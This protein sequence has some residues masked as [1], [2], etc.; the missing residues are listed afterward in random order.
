MADLP[1]T[2]GTRPAATHS[3]H[4]DYLERVSP[5]WL[6]NATPQ[7][8][9]QLKDGPVTLPDEYLQASA[10]QRQALQEKFTA[11]F[12]AQS[13]LD[14]AMASLQ[15][16]DSF[17]APLLTKALQAQF[18]VTLD[19]NTTLLQLNKTI[20]A[21]V[22]GIDIGSFEA[23]RLPLLQAALHNFEA[24][25][26]QPGAFHASS[27][28]LTQAVGAQ[29]VETL[30]TSL[31]VAQFTGLC[32]SLDIG[33]QYQRYLKDYLQ[34]T[35]TVAAQLLR[36]TFIGARKA[37]LAASAE[38]ALLQK[39]IEP[40]DYRMIVSV[41][42]GEK[43][44][45]MGK[46]QVWF[47]D[48]GLMKK[49][50]T[51][52]VVF[53]ICEKYRYTDEL[54]LYVP[55]D[56]HHP[57][58]RYTPEQ[59][60]ALFKQR[61]TAHDQPP[62][63]DGSPTTYQRFF[64]Q[65]VAYGDRPYYFSELTEDAP[66]ASTAGSL[67]HYVPLLN[68]LA[69]GIS[70]FGEV[71][72]IK[73]LPPV[74]RA[75]Q[76]PN[77]DPF[78]NP[79]GLLHKGRGLWA[80]NPDLWDYLYEQH[81]DKLIADAR[82]HAVPTAE[83][84]ARVRSEKLA[85][86]LNI[87]LLALNVASMFVPVLGEVMMGVMAAQLLQETFEGALEWTEGD[88]RAAKAHLL[89]VAENLAFLA[90]MA[91]VGKG[92]ATYAA[93][94]PVPLIEGLDPVTLPNGQERLSKA[95]VSAY[96]SP[97]TLPA[98]I[99]AN[100]QGQ[101]VYAGKTYIRQSGKVYEKTF[102][103]TLGCWRIKHPTDSEAY[104]PRLSHNGAGAWRHALERPLT[105]DRTTL[106]RRLGPVADG[107]SD[108]Q[109]LRIADISGTSD[110]AL[111]KM[112]LDNAL[113]PAPLTD[114]M[115]L[116]KA[117]AEV[118]QVIEQ[119]S[120]GE[121][122]DARYLYTL[123]LVTELPRWPVG[124]VLEV[125]EGAGLTG[126]SQR[127]GVERL[128]R[129]VKLKP[130]IRVSRADVLSSQL[131][132]Q[133]LAALDESEI[134]GLLGSEA[135][136]VI[137]H[138]PAE[139][140]KQLAEHARAREPALFESLYKGTDAR[141]PTV[142]KLQRLYPGLS[143]PAAQRALAE[144]GAEQLARL[145]DTGRVP[146]ALQENLQGHVQQGRLGHAYAGL[147][148]DNML[149]ADSKRLAL[150][151]LSKL[152]GWTDALRLEVR[153][154]DI[155][156]DLLD[157]IG[158]PAATQRKYLVKQGPRYQ[159]F[160]ERGEALNSVAR[161]GDNF[162]ASL[163]HAL[164]DDARQALGLPQV[165]QSL[166]LR[167]AIIDYATGHRPESAQIVEGRSRT[168][169][170]FNP[171]RRLSPKRFGYPASGRGQGVSPS[172][173]SRVQDVYPQLT[174]GQAN[175][176]ILQQMLADQSDSQIFNL[177]NNRL[178]E[179]RNLES[180][181]DSWVMSASP[182]AFVRSHSY[183]DSRPAMAQ[184]LKASWR[185]G[186]LPELPGATN[187]TLV[188]DTLLPSLE[189]DFS[190]VRTLNIRGRVLIDGQVEQL[191]GYFPNVQKLSLAGADTS[192]ASVPQ[193]LEGL[194]ALTNLSIETA[195]DLTE[196]VLARLEGL[197][198]LEELTLHSSW[199]SPRPL[200]VG[201]MSALRSLTVSG[202]GQYMFPDGVFE[203]PQLQRLDLKGA[204]IDS[205]P[206]QLFEPGR[207]Y[208]WSVLSLKWSR[209]SRERFRAAYEFVKAH[210][211][212]LMDQDEMVRD[213]CTG[214]LSQ[215][216]GRSAYSNTVVGGRLIAQ[217]FEYWP[218]TQA[219]LQAI[220]ALTTEYAQLSARFNVWRVADGNSLEA[221]SRSGIDSALRDCWYQGLLKRY[222]IDSPGVLSL[223]AMTV[224]DLPILPTEGFAHV[225]LLRVQNSR[226]PTEQMST[227]IR[228][229]SGLQSVDASN[230][231][232]TGLSVMPGEWAA[233]EHLD[234]SH[235]P[236]ETL[237]V[238]RL[239]QLRALSLRGT[240]LSTWP[241]GA[242]RLPQLDWLDLRDTRIT[243]V[244][245]AALASDRMLL[246]TN[247]VGTPLS[248]EAQAQ[249]AAAQQK[250]EHTR[251]LD[252]GTL[253]RF[254]QQP[255][256]DVFPPGESATAIARQLLPLLPPGST[257]RALSLPQ[258]LQR[259]HPTLGVE[260][261]R[262]WLTR[263]R[264]ETL[265][266]AERVQGWEQTSDALTRRLNSWLF[267]RQSTFARDLVATSRTRQLAAQRI[268]DCWRNGLAPAAEGAGR[269]LNLH[270]LTLGELPQLPA[271]FSHVEGLNLSGVQLS[272]EGSNAFLGAFPQLRRLVL[273]SNPLQ[274]MPAAVQGMTRLERLELSAIS[275]GDPER[276]Y[277]T[278]QSL[279]HLQSLDLSNGDLS[280][281]RVDGLPHL[282]TLDLSNNQLTD[283]PDGV[284]QATDLRSLNLSSN[285]IESIPLGAL[286]GAHDP[287]MRGTDLSD[288]FSLPLDE[289]YR[290]Q[291]FAERTGS[292]G[293]LGL[294][295]RDIQHLVNDLEQPHDSDSDGESEEPD[296]APVLP[297][298]VLAPS[299]TSEAER[300]PWFE[301]LAPE[302]QVSKRILWDQLEAEPG[303]TAFFNLLSSL[304]DTRDF[305]VARAA[306][307]RRVWDVMEAAGSNTE[308]RET[309]FA[310]SSSHGTCNDGRLLTFTGLEIKVYVF[311]T[312]EG[313]DP[314][315]LALKG[316]AL[317]S[318]S[319]RL[320]RLEQV[321]K[322]AA[323]KMTALSD[324]AEVRLQYLIGLKQRLDLP[325]VPERM[326][327][328]TP[329]SGAAMN[330]EAQAILDAEHTDGFY[331]N[332]ISR[333]YWV[334]YLEKKYADEFVALE[335]S[336][337]EKTDRLETEHPQIDDAYT[338]AL[339]TLEHELKLARNLKLIELSRRETGEPLA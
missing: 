224:R 53:Q 162:F 326:R 38:L 97:V 309:L 273:S 255:M 105:W 207:E 157:S 153:E 319:R 256:P 119:V 253:S 88:R 169:A 180:T 56:P 37:D 74:A 260:G 325:G 126:P 45:W 316:T 275:F 182:D 331:E 21:G 288:N 233:L 10:Q 225:T 302:D 36:D 101:Y 64:S 67:G 218:S 243:H 140:R 222:G 71:A 189:A 129:G 61:F 22:F 160:N 51:G 161:E 285:Q 99:R 33:G 57:L 284:L 167:R 143:A 184:A 4:R 46:K 15:D 242:E 321:E 264:G 197:T 115:R 204:S 171:P 226:V 308:L 234:L 183:L 50:M 213:Y 195:A 91:G 69:K 337:D 190:H 144:A 94:K 317:L 178:R 202:L 96:E 227:F 147:H 292:D 186:A 185:N 248:V 223:P 100:A 47:S 310:M 152:P 65:F 179:W 95:N 11:S 193:A 266:V 5:A 299:V 196:P 8:R 293:A 158:S 26:C 318:L 73:E 149:S 17:A 84:D 18:N 181:L 76:R 148:M 217:F 70:P 177:L 336:R 338:A 192:I 291:A 89:D 124:R 313:I 12:T 276:W 304:R 9:A 34:P 24:R 250:F 59:M 170:G 44:P 236:L 62:A 335:R 229:F 267:T 135:A 311:S 332:L 216:L 52:C 191:L 320:F 141:D 118:A 29:K 27:G 164:P 221:L 168:Q 220:E 263:L 139:F 215:A 247:L 130:P 134:T 305:S 114:T 7:R 117:D 239:G 199:L 298:E 163:M 19:V 246:N 86:L 145:R 287:L 166:E 245:E 68:E 228:G 110:D 212:H 151:T 312:L 32:R 279:E 259:L 334:E 25:E 120:T 107:F 49:R 82:S 214:Q 39:H 85:R 278:L 301:N 282:Q 200:N 16:I 113:P 269:E 330:A 146:L 339:L 30:N 127:Y 209:F 175:G 155:T 132:A 173:V 54:I 106:M 211:E 289:L 121:A 125:F 83:V 261:S 66:K 92:L 75:R 150:H 272:G 42:N 109:L 3:I 286:E 307:T 277:P 137:E 20:E 128:F 303:S 188:G 257:Q 154:G 172:L 43:N 238:S 142:A 31:T 295:D 103:E 270:G 314:T 60:K 35:D 156:G 274:V 240:P 232:L 210:P 159:A 230:C 194:S 14:K 306:L 290:L 1:H 268:L 40:A 87:G 136:R 315:D 131:P 254:A 244:P 78:L 300:K 72:G 203:L 327:Y 80:E 93:A 271:E 262:L 283:W 198:G 48:L 81:R 252:E 328:A 280:S 102:D 13:A 165:S 258:R 2:T 111:R 90:V 251:G 231:G 187:L 123:P 297:D 138:R 41:I 249:L 205:L 122:V 98:D 208:L 201:R 265:P 219:R 63:D 206:P 77:P 58:K 237:D 116:F 235:N 112:H 79:G 333:D 241:A 23:L 55:H 281:F 28:F 296:E 323:S 6:V 329:I 174:E 176:F 322:L 104:Q 294:S 133:I 324:P 108:E